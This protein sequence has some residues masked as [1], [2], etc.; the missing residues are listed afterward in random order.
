MDQSK[1]HFLKKNLPFLTVLFI[2]GI[3]FLYVSEYDSNKGKETFGVN[4]DEKAYVEDLEQRVAAMLEEME[5]VEQ[6]HVM[7]TLEGSTRYQFEHG[8]SNALDRGSS[9]YVG[10]LIAETGTGGSESPLLLEV[11][12]PKIK[13]VSVVCRGAKN[14]QTR[15]KIIGLIA[16]TLNLTKNKIYVTE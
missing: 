6:A 5:G 13:G 3:I 2:L 16:S 15:E 8:G 14:I 11:E 4:F 12:S 10:S 1:K 9:A 7:I